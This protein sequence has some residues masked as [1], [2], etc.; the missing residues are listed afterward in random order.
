MRPIETNEITQAITTSP[1]TRQRTAITDV[2]SRRRPTSQEVDTTAATPTNDAANNELR[3]RI[4]ELE[5]ELA[6]TKTKITDLQ[7]TIDQQTEQIQA[8]TAKSTSLIKQVEI[9]NRNRQVASREVAK[10][11]AERDSLRGEV[12]SEAELQKQLKTAVQ[13]KDTE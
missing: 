11:K 9:R 7:E 13:Q 2:A 1:R 3:K 12:H 8:T 10:L 4:E 6:A 5:K